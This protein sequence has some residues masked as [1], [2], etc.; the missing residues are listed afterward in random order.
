MTNNPQTRISWFV[1]VQVVIVAAGVATAAHRRRT[2]DATGLL[3]AF[4]NKPLELRPLHDDD[5]VVTDEQLSAVLEKLKPRLRHDNPKIN[6]IDH[7]L[8][9]WGVDAAFSDP[10]CLSGK[11]MRAIL[12]HHPVYSQY[13]GDDAPPLLISDDRGIRVRTR[14]G[15]ASASHVDHTLAVLAEVGTPLDYT[16]DTSEGPATMRQILS[17]S[18]RAFSLNQLEYEWSTLAYAL[19]LEP[20]DRWTSSEGQEITFD[21]LADRIMRQQLNQGVCMGNHR[22]HALVTLLRVNEESPILSEE[23]TQRITD[24]LLDVTSRFVASQHPD[25]YW[26][27]S[28]PAGSP[29][30]EPQE[31]DTE[32]TL[33]LRILG[34]GH[35]L[36]WWAL[37]P[38]EVHPPREVVIRAGQWLS[39][40]I[41]EMD[42]DDIQT[43]YTFLTHAGRALALWRGGFPAD[44]MPEALPVEVEHRES[45]DE[46]SESSREPSPAGE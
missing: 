24:H 12:L 41:Q 16:I 28:W 30:A 7:A 27:R 45:V 1:V 25:G 11:E 5:R 46:E 13:W 32:N 22:L 43:N 17:R 10:E 35:V 42:P 23:G 36:E 44:F 18:L 21:R 2:I 37:A 14:A 31:G 38:V 20:T 26:I 40:T 9:M 8:R 29:P 39:R 4:R 15:D 19:Y 3:P 6:H 34:T 33:Q